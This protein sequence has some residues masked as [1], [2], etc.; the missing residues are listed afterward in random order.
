M[1]GHTRHSR[2]YECKNMLVRG[3]GGKCSCMALPST[4]SVYSDTL[5][6]H[7]PFK[8]TTAISVHKLSVIV[9]AVV[10]VFGRRRKS[11][12]THRNKY[13]RIAFATRAD[14]PRNNYMDVKLILNQPYD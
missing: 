8:P 3:G 7:H 11:A 2:E 9:G 10:V 13:N 14:I 6:K 12:F 5:N 1:H 4:S